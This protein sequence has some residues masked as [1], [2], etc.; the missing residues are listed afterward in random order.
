M[1]FSTD[2]SIIVIYQENF[3]LNW[4]QNFPFFTCGGIDTNWPKGEGIWETIQS[5]LNTDFSQHSYLA[6][7]LH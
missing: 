7:Q 6:P 5:V 3:A 4:P 1:L 2:V